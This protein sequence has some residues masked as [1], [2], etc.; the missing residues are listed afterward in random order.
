MHGRKIPLERIGRQMNLDQ[1]FLFKWRKGEYERLN[2]DIILERI[3]KL[4]FTVP[5]DPMSALD[6]LMK[7][8]HTRNLKFWHDHSDILNHCYA[9]FLISALYYPAVYLTDEE[10]KERYPDRASV[11]V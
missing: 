5:S 10:F 2:E 1:D 6:E 7:V 9:S 11:D 4:Q 3:S 8:E